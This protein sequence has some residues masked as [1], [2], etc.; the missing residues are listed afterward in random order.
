MHS[1]TLSICIQW[2]VYYKLIMMLVCENGNVL[3]AQDLYFRMRC[4][5]LSTCFTDVFCQYQTSNTSHQVSSDTPCTL[6][7]IFP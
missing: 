3:F 7:T 2:Q 1:M 6:E 4:H 5:P